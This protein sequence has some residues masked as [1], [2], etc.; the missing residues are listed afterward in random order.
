MFGLLFYSLSLSYLPIRRI[1]Y[2]CIS[3]RCQFQALWEASLIFFDFKQPRDLLHATADR[4]ARS[5]TLFVLGHARD[6]TVSPIHCQTGTETKYSA[7]L[8]TAP[9]TPSLSKIPHW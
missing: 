5:G 9:W 6:W 4:S 2:R 7:E 3:K 1:S 8:R